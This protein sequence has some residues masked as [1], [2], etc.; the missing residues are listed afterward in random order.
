[1]PETKESKGDGEVDQKS[2]FDPAKIRQILGSLIII[3]KEKVVSESYHQ[4]DKVRTEEEELSSSKVNPPSRWSYSFCLRSH[5]YQPKISHVKIAK[6][7]HSYLEV[8]PYQPRLES[9][10]RSHLVLFQQSLQ[11]SVDTL[12]SPWYHHHQPPS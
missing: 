7:P 8:S 1:M 10:R 4:P 9:Q 3:R 5:S 11:E 2:S 12:Y 6:P